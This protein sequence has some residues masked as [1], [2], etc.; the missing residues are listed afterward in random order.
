MKNSR[1]NTQLPAE[2]IHFQRQ[3]DYIYLNDNKIVD[4]IFAIDNL[5]ML[6]DQFY[7]Y[8]GSEMPH[9]NN[10]KKSNSS[11]VFK[12]DI[13]GRTIKIARPFTQ[14]VINRMSGDLKEKLR[15]MVYIPSGKRHSDIFQSDFVIDFIKDYYD[16][17]IKLIEQQ[18]SE[19]SEK[20]LM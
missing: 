11:K 3:V 16:N 1:N 6:L 4:S 7:E 2:Y 14:F 15:S 9:G 5:D 10:I 17:D 13:L 18:Q 20:V 19:K 12:N 8:I